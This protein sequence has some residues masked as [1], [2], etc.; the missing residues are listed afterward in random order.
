[1]AAGDARPVVPIRDLAALAPLAVV[2]DAFEVTGPA[3]RSV[4]AS[5]APPARSLLTREAGPPVCAFLLSPSSFLLPPSSFLLPPSR[6]LF[7]CESPVTA[8]S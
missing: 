2:T 3:T 1:M 6:P 5:S 4:G 8:A 7:I